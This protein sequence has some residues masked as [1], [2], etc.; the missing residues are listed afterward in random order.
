VNQSPSG[1][2]DSLSLQNLWRQY[3]QNWSKICRHQSLWSA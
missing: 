1:Y 3:M 2:T